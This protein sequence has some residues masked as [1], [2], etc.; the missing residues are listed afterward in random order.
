MDPDARPCLSCGYDLRAAPAGGACPECAAPT[1]KSLYGVDIS[2][3]PHSRLVRDALRDA[4]FV[5]GRM[6]EIIWGFIF[7]GVLFG[8][9]AILIGAAVPILGFVAGVALVGWGCIELVQLASLAKRFAPDAAG[10]CRAAH[11]G[12]GAFG[13]A[14]AIP[15][16]AEVSA[17]RGGF[18]SVALGLM[19]TLVLAG[20]GMSLTL[21]GVAKAL[22]RHAERLGAGRLVADW[23]AVGA[24]QGWQGV[25]AAIASPVIPVSL[26]MFSVSWISLA[27][28][29]VALRRRI[30]D[31]LFDFT[32]P[33]CRADVGDD[34]P[35]VCPHCR[36]RR[37]AI[38]PFPISPADGAT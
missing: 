33:M 13:V 21:W 20:G 27:P 25:A 22:Q 17:S 9:L 29:L 28:R 10:A 7:G 15:F 32:C 16:I 35:E 26:V 4:A 19:A 34:R 24:R 12:A 8:V 11:I 5:A 31:D 38:A 1:A 30:T 6:D 36:H 14:W 3:L 23:R 2:D 18:G 37:R